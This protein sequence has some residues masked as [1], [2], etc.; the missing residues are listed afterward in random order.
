MAA[1]RDQEMGG[2]G[3]GPGMGDCLDLGWLFWGAGWGFLDV[4]TVCGWLIGLE[5]GEGLDGVVVE[6]LWRK[7]EWGRGSISLTEDI[8]CVR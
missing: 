3:L 7:V 5:V 8:I 1:A 2:E 6:R 4:W